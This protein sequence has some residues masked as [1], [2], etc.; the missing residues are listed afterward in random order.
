MPV[1]FVPCPRTAQV[2]MRYEEA[3]EKVENVYHFLGASDWT[4]TLLAALAVAMIGWENTNMKVFRANNTILD[5]AY[6]I[7][8]SVNDGAWDVSV[9]PV[10]GTRTS[11]NLPNNC[12]WAVKWITAQRGRSFRGRTYHIGM[13][14]DMLQGG[15]QEITTTTATNMLAAYRTLLTTT[16][17]NSAVPVV[18]SIRHNNAYRTTGV[19]T[20]ITDATYSDLVIDSQRRRLPFHN[21]HR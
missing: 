20:P 6:A 3:G 5:L 10:Q 21:V 1:P 13:T 11:P 18:R 7:D 17:P 9:T 12:S 16:W 4:S 19:M 8:L 2:N 15:S 14:E